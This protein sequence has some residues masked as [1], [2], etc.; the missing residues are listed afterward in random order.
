[1]SKMIW[2]ECDLTQ[3]QGLVRER[4][5]L[6][7]ENKALREAAQ[8]LQRAVDAFFQGEGDQATVLHAQTYL[9]TVLRKKP[10][11][12]SRTPERTKTL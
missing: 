4:N 8:T 2:R 6:A 11:S 7:D 10:R 3:I 12:H 5:Q 1:M 9:N